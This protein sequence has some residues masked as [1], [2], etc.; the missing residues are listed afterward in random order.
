RVLAVFNHKGGTGK[1]TTSVHVAAGLALSGH[2]VL[3]VDTDGQGNVAAA[4]G[5]TAER[6]LYH[7]IVMGL[8]YR[9]AVVSARPGLDV[10]LSNETLAAAELYIAGQRQRD[11]ILA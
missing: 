6:T 5:L 3:L 10:L 4:L 8:D 1:T 11:R 9:E 2:R 7:V